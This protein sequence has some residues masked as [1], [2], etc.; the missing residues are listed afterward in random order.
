[1]TLFQRMFPKKAAPK[2][3]PAV[4]TAQMFINVKDI[5]GGK[6]YTKDGFVFMFLRITPISIDLKTAGE[7]KRL[8]RQIAAEFSGI[9]EAFKIIAVSRPLDLTPLINE[10]NEHSRNAEEAERKE[11]I[12]REKKDINLCMLDD[13]AVSRQFY[14]ALWTK[15]EPDSPVKRMALEMTERFRN[16]QINAELLS[17]TEIIQL[18]HI[19]TNPDAS[20]SS[21]DEDFVPVITSIGG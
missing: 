20:I 2:T 12:R 8:A 14:L 1:M 13:N 16:V 18:C 21:D 17:D 11:V 15:D 6:L 19:I 7:Q 4:Q 3:S 9:R 5:S 10:L